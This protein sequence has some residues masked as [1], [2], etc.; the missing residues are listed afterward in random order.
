MRKDNKRKESQKNHRMHGVKN[1][2]LGAVYASSNIVKRGEIDLNVEPKKPLTF[3]EQI[4]KLEE[5][6]IVVKDKTMA[7]SVLM[8]VSYFTLSGYFKPFLD[9]YD[10][11]KNNVTLDMI[12]RIYKFDRRL[13]SICAFLMDKFEEQI[14]TRI[15]YYSAHYYKDK[16]KI[17]VDFYLKAHFFER[18]RSER[19][20]EA[21]KRGK[22]PSTT[23]DLGKNFRKS[24]YENV[25]AS[26][27]NKIEFAKHYKNKYS[28]KYPIWVAVKMCSLWM[29]EFMYECFPKELR[30]E[31]AKSFNTQ[32]YNLGKWLK[33][34]RYLRNILAH[35]G[36]LYGFNLEVIN[37]PKSID[38]MDKEVSNKVFQYIYIFKQLSKNDTADVAGWKYVTRSFKELFESEHYKDIIELDKIGFPENWEQLLAL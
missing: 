24:F 38:Y 1:E 37:I 26:I 5:K 36:R 23:I 10:H 22:D 19:M 20:N 7:K 18:R 8:N 27:N 29:I 9:F 25:E 35:N 11:A 6:G 12:Y 4:Q 31:I 13:L 14:K 17:P 34:F 32:E 30:E 3:D 33:N 16:D 15:A 2:N 28:G 21:E